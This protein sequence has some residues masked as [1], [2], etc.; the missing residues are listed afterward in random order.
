MTVWYSPRYNEKNAPLPWNRSTRIGIFEDRVKNW[1]INQ[2]RSL[3]FRE[4]R[5]A[6]YA[7]LSVI[8]T[9]FEMISRYH[10]GQTEDIEAFLSKRKLP[11]DSGE[12]FKY[13]LGLLANHIK[14]WPKGQALEDVAYTMYKALRC[15][16]YHSGMARHGVWIVTTNP[17]A[18]RLQNDELIVNPETLVE[19]VS[20]HFDSYIERLRHPNS[21]YDHKLL[22]NFEKRF[23]MEVTK[24]M[25]EIHSKGVFTD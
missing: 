23:E 7:A 8:L 5:D 17:A 10:T 25:E 9:Y 19:N 21:S 14:S 15:G 24:K 22:D 1:T 13:G 4:H 2:A 11:S 18:L 3:L 12:C 6:G 20:L 16:L